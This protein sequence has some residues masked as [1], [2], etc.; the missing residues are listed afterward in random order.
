LRAKGRS[1]VHHTTMLV[2]SYA[3]LQEKEKLQKLLASLEETAS[4]AEAEAVVNCLQSSKLLNE[5]T[6]FAI[7]TGQHDAALSI[8]VDEQCLYD[9]AIKFIAKF[10]APRV[11][12]YLEMYGR[13]LLRA[14]REEMMALLSEM[15]LTEGGSVNTSLLLQLFVGDE[16][17]G[18]SLMEQLAARG[19]GGTEM[20]NTIIELNMRTYNKEEPFDVF[21]KVLKYVSKENEERVRRQAE[22]LKCDP[23]VEALLRRMRDLPSL[24][25]FHMRRGNVEKVV[26][27]ANEINTTQSWL[28][29][30][31]FVA[32]MESPVDDEIM[33]KIL[34]K[35]KQTR[36]LHPLV[37]LEVLSKSARLNVAAVKKYV[38][39]WLS[40][41]RE[42]I[43][44]DKAAIASSEQKIQEVGKQ[45]ESLHFNTQVLQVSKCCACDFALQLPSIF[46]LCRHAFHVHC[47]D[48]Y[49]DKADLC[50]K[51]SVEGAAAVRMDSDLSIFSRN[52]YGEFVERMNKAEDSMEIISK[53]ISSGL[54]DSKKNGVPL[55]AGLSP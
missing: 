50:P 3:R 29:T 13:R 43:S 28:D 14:N 5:A 55:P 10:E 6:L 48:S 23:V 35:V 42:K 45:I 24:H 7:K 52:A 51:C 37:I 25:S 49:A 21:D 46:F 8:L 19:A 34:E 54:F 12:R 9:R 17:S 32:K 2:N 27:M 16:Q 47:F 18:A 33:E 30:L 36:V 38:V 40:E 20:M 31:S 1:N 15:M 26:E 41:Q 44:A 11:E 22:E 39:Q 4:D 53:Y